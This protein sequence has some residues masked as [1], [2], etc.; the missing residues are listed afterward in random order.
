VARFTGADVAGV[1]VSAIGPCLLPVDA[2]L[3]PLRKGILYGVD[4][5][6]AREIDELNDELGAEAVYAQG[7]MAFSSQAI[8]PKLRWLRR[9]EPT[10][11]RGRTPSTPPAPGWWPS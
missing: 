5:R 10:S 6:A 11:G 3:R 8:G 4:V 7:G 1:A 2:D 9:H